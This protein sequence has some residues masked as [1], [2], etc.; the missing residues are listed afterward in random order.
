M[1]GPGGEVP[2]DQRRNLQKYLLQKL[3]GSPGTAG[4]YASISGQA[5]GSPKISYNPFL[6]ML[7]GRPDETFQDLQGSGIDS[8]A[9][10]GQYADPGS[11]I[12]G[13]PGLGVYNPGSN[14]FDPNAGASS[15]AGALYPSGPSGGGGIP[16]HFNP[17]VLPGGGRDGQ[18]LNG[19]API[20]GWANPTQIGAQAAQAS[21]YQGGPNSIPN[22]MSQ[23][24]PAMGMN[25]AGLDPAI[26][27][28]L[29]AH[30]NGGA[31]GF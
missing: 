2:N 20:A 31:R 25:I 16:S 5:P 7:A 9:G 21:R 29:M 12:Q 26:Q 27:Q 22:Y 4:S 24:T 13:Q 14:P 17:V 10:A 18:T 30:L 23:V 15:G 19:Q 3:Q 28:A 1:G 8:N 6:Q 11:S